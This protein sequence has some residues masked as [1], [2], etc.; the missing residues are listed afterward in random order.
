MYRVGGV[1]LWDTV[2]EEGG[3]GWGGKRT[4]GGGY[5]RLGRIPNGGVG[6]RLRQT[7]RCVA[8]AS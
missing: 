6:A 4:V 5:G 1:V 7:D 8:E 3:Q 2:H